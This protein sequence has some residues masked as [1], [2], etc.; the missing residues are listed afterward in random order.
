[1]QVFTMCYISYT[2]KEMQAWKNLHKVAKHV[3]LIHKNGATMKRLLELRK[4]TAGTSS[5]QAIEVNKVA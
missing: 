1:M 2:K 3:P 5:Y 4:K